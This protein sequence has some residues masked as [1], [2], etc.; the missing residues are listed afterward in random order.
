MH[1]K[2]KSGVTMDK[3]VPNIIEHFANISTPVVENR[4][5]SPEKNDENVNSTDKV[6]SSPLGFFKFDQSSS[7][8]EPKKLRGQCNPVV[9]QAV[10]LQAQTV[11]RLLPPLQPQS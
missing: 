8:N 5:G 9:P 11:Q 3:K 10:G 1:G 7:L 6:I 2:N 4:E